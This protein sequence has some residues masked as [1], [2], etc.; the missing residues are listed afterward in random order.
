MQP[1]SAAKVVSRIFLTLLLASAI[2]CAPAQ[3][4]TFKVLHTFKGAPN[5]GA[6]PLTQLTLDAAGGNLY[7]T[8]SGGGKGICSNTGCGTAFRLNRNG[9]KIY[10]FSGKNGQYPFA[11]LYQDSAGDFYGTTEEGGDFT[12]FSQGCGTVFKLSKTGKETL[13]YSFTGD[14]D[15]S[16]PEALLVGDA[17]G[18]LY[19]TTSVGGGFPGYG[20]V[21]KIDAGGETILHTFTGPPSGGADG[22][23]SYYGVIRDAAD[24]LYGAATEGG[25]YGAGAVYKLDTSGNET[26]LYSF[27][28]GS[29]G[30][31]PASVL[32]FD[33]QGNLYGTTG[34]GGN[35]NCAGGSGCGVVYELSPQPG[36]SWTE[37][38]LYIFCSLSNCTDGESPG[39]GP[40]VLDAAGNL[41]GTTSNGGAYHLNCD[42]AGCGVV[43]KLDASGKE[44]VLYS[45]TGGADGASPSAGLTMDKA[46]SLYGTAFYGGDVSCTLIRAPG[47]GVVFKLTP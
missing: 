7:G 17:A 39:A 37:T 2:L 32:L 23:Y 34:F 29:D 3:A 6:L 16:F 36:G 46:G 14:P 38:T 24:N 35:L 31:Y 12:C 28:G 40:L 45:F 5:D 21:F 18:N 47:C 4:Q 1:S 19:G 11:G 25:A 42:G 43:F 13:L 9:I 30:A 26:L 15:G 41:Y 22:A 20:T 8:T 10:S 44:T 27:H 33:L